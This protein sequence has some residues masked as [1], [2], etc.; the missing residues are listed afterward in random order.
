MAQQINFT[1]D[2]KQEFILNLDNGETITLRIDYIAIFQGFYLINYVYQEQKIFLN[3]RI[4]LT[5]FGILDQFKNI[6]PFDLLC[7]S[8]DNIEPIFQ[9]DFTSGRV[10]LTLISQEEKQFILQNV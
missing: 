6:L 9:N 10:L 1:G 3:L 8:N 5:P 7:Y 4:T 2:I